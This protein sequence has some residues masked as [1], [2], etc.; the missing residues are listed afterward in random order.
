MPFHKSE[1]LQEIFRTDDYKAFLLGLWRSNGRQKL[2]ESKKRKSF[3]YIEILRNEL[4]L[5]W[6][7]DNLPLNVPMTDLLIF[8]EFNICEWWSKAC[9]IIELQIYRELCAIARLV[10]WQPSILNHKNFHNTDFYKWWF[11]CIDAIRNCQI[12]YIKISY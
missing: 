2:F 10:K 11:Y 5:N 1:Y 3:L 7:P 12:K 9:L 6:T 4:P 8:Q